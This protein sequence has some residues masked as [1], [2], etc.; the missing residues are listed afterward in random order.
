MPRPLPT[1]PPGQRYCS[2]MVGRGRSGP[3]IAVTADGSTVEAFGN[4]LSLALD[5]P[6]VDKTGITGKFDIR[7]EFGIDEVTPRFKADGDMGRLWPPD[8][9]DGPAGASIF[10]AIQE[11]LGLKLE[12]AKG[13]GEFLVIDHVE[14]PTEN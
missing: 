6:V 8:S 11:Q 4:L 5:R 2:A 7:L 14:K 13:P 9:T 12:P 1:L 3:N 10:T